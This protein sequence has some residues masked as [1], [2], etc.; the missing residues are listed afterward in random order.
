MSRRRVST[1]IA[2][3]INAKSK[4]CDSICWRGR[5]WWNTCIIIII[6]IMNNSD[7]N[8]NNTNRNLT[9]RIITCETIYYCPADDRSPKSRATRPFGTRRRVCVCVARGVVRIYILN[10]VLHTTGRCSGQRK[11]DVYVYSIWKIHIIIL[12]FIFLI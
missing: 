7:N 4:H 8:K 1:D 11:R 2:P 10:Y 3:T 5:L 9:I 12:V 6:I